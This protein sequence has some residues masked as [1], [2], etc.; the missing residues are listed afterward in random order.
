VKNSLQVIASFI[1]LQRRETESPA[2]R[3]ELDVIAGRIEALR[4]VYAKLYL[5][6]RHGETDLCAYLR[7]LCASLLR[8]QLAD[9]KAIKLDVQCEAMSIDLDQAVALGLFTTEF[10]VNSVKHAFPDGRGAL[11]VRLDSG[12]G[13][14]ARLLLADSGRGHIFPRTIGSGLGLMEQLA[15]Q[16]GARLNW[17]RDGGTRAELLF[18]PARS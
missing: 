9:G 10:V 15:V 8:F 3:D 4:V 12:E 14:R 11:T 18:V 13:G 2:A 7:D 6:D 1:S 5:A 17:Q 16:A